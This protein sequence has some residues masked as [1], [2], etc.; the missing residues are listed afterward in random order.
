[1]NK[2]VI[3]KKKTTKKKKNEHT[4]KKVKGQNKKPKTD[5]LQLTP[6]EK[7]Y[8]RLHRTL[9]LQ[10]ELVPQSC[11]YSNTRKHLKKRYWDTIRKY[12]YSK[13][14]NLCEIC[15][16]KGENHPVECHEVW[17]YN[18][19]T[20]VQKLGYFQAIC[21]LCHEVK[22][23][24]LAGILGNGI[25]AFKRFKK[26]NN[27]DKETAAEIIKAVF[28]QWR[29]RSQFKWKLDIERLKKYGIDTNELR[30]KSK[31]KIYF[32]D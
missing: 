30:S 17:I 12:H 7:K 28:K 23:I 31:H 21:P 27:F 6:Q 22:H 2:S 11:W 14:N 18:E 16:G 20:L 15:G 9:K 10:I 32:K 24:G 3:K 19:K 4:L 26:L 5:S 13:A 29:I 8:L 1:M 25:R